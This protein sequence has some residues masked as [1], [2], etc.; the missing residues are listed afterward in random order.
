MGHSRGLSENDSKSCCHFQKAREDVPIQ[1]FT[2]V[3]RRLCTCA[4]YDT[5]LPHLGR[6][7]QKSKMMPLG[8]RS[9]ESGCNLGGKPLI[10]LG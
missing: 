7:D 3:T 2:V 10:T 4:S 6:D 8:A 5:I 9:H 1:D